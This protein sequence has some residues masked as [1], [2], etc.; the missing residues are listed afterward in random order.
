ME[1]LPIVDQVRA[2]ANLAGRM[3]VSESWVAGLENPK[4]YKGLGHLG[5]V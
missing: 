1:A 2:I 5:F 3:N 4:A